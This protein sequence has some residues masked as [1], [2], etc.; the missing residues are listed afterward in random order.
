MQ[1]WGVIVLGT[2]ELFEVTQTLLSK[3]SKQL[4]DPPDQTWVKVLFYSLTGALSDRCP[5]DGVHISS[6][7][8]S[9]SIGKNS[10]CIG[11]CRDNRMQRETLI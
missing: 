5:V 6:E 9:A 10:L 1:L 8:V 7:K 2:F 3:P 4:P 11:V